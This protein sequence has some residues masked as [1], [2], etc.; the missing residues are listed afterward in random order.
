MPVPY[1]KL[2]GEATLAMIIRFT[3]AGVNGSVSAKGSLTGKFGNHE[4][5]GS[6]EAKSIAGTGLSRCDGQNAP[7][8]IGTIA[9]VIG[10]LNEYVGKGN[11]K[12]PGTRDVSQYASSVSLSKSLSLKPTGVDLLAKTGSPDLE[13]KL[14][15]LAM[16]LKLGVTGRLDIIDALAMA[17]TGPGATAIREARA[18]MASGQHVKGKLEAYLEVGAEG[19]LTHSIMS[20][21]T[22]TIP[23]NIPAP[24][25]TSVSEVFRGEIKI[26]GVLSVGVEIEAEIWIFS[27]KAGASGTVHTSWA[28]ALRKQGAKREKNY[29]FEGLIIELKAHAEAGFR[30]G[31]D[32]ADE[33]A[34]GNNNTD[35]AHAASAPSSS[36]LESQ[37]AQHLEKSS[38]EAKRIASSG[39]AG[40]A[41]GRTYTIFSPE[42]SGWEKY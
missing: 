39:I 36:D 29:K 10:T 12:G 35:G 31:N 24:E 3:T 9:N 21:V 32:D 1:L 15:G 14:G 11:T 6:A 20:G 19:M 41:G 25:T 2:D 23:A 37:V 34:F 16:E 30:S 8:M 33:S 4:I 27:G 17:Y 40:I 28:W 5:T 22:I 38:A 18:V 13:L 7:G 42:D 26:R